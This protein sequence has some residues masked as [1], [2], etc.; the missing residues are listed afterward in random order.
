MKDK[1]IVIVAAQ[2]RPLDIIK[3][4]DGVATISISAPTAA[5]SFFMTGM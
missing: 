5:V 4:K 3:R 1:L 2:K